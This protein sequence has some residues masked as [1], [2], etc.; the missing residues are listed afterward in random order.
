[1]AAG[2]SDVVTTE[3][4]TA[5][6]NDGVPVQ[7]G[8]ATTE[9]FITTGAN[10][11]VWIFDNSSKTAID[12][13]LGNEVYGRLTEAAGVYTLSY[14]SLQSGVET[15]YSLTST[16]IDFY[17]NYN[18]LFKNI[19]NDANIRLRAVPVGEDPG[20]QSGR[21]IRNEQVTVTATN[22]L[23]D[24]AKTPIDNSVALY[25][26]GKAEHEGA[27]A[28]FTRVGKALTWDATDAEYDLETTDMVYAHYDTL[29]A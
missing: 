25:V 5:A 3:V 13:G 18:Y 8:A 19:P 10:N 6:G 29:E 27:S 21:P 7:V 28:A 22:T 17:V 4:T 11:K 1:T 14:Y 23:S 16:A 26:N 2:T 12:D 24:L 9:G 15:A 20:S